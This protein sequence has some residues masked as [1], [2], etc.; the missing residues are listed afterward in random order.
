MSASCCAVTGPRIVEATARQRTP[1]PARGVPR[2]DSPC[3]RRR[4]VDP[5]SAPA[6]RQGPFYTSELRPGR[7]SRPPSVST[8]SRASIPGCRTGLEGDRLDAPIGR[9]S[10]KLTSGDRRPARDPAIGPDRSS[11]QGLRVVSI[12][13]VANRQRCLRSSRS[14]T[15]AETARSPHDHRGR[16]AYEAAPIKF[17]RVTRLG[18]MGVSSSQRQ[19]RAPASTTPYKPG[20]FA[21][22]RQDGRCL[23][24]RP[25]RPRGLPGDVF[26]PS[27]A[28]SRARGESSTTTS[29]AGSLTRA[30][31]LIIETQSCGRGVVLHPENVISITDG[32]IW[33]GGSSRA[34]TFSTLA[35][36]G[37]QRGHLWCPPRRQRPDQATKRF[38]RTPAP[39]PSPIPPP[40]P[41]SLEGC[42]AVASRPRR[43]TPRRTLL[44]ARR[45]LVATLNQKERSP[46]PVPEDQ[47]LQVYV[48]ATNSTS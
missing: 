3:S 22:T 12:D 26:Y 36:P 5:R 34:R 47:V 44:R 41:R 39:R 24:R 25:R 31:C 16:A 23:L 19:G 37:H 27:Q 46:L 13:D 35:S 18:A 7:I 8:A 9:A 1:A 33:G 10:A 42:R 11:Q 20:A 45:R 4:I 14:R 30:L 28:D 48:R 21:L 6:R 40:Y 38:A 32:Q 17:R 29:A 2:G 15:L 43:P